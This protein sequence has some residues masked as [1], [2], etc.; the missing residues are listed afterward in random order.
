MDW[1]D[2]R[3]KVFTYALSFFLGV[4]VVEFVLPDGFAWWQR[5]VFG[6]IPVGMLIEQGLARYMGW[7]RPQVDEPAEHTQQPP[8]AYAPIG[9]PDSRR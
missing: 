4:L 7:A 2:T 5:I 9:R 8:V 3:H 1:L 6:W